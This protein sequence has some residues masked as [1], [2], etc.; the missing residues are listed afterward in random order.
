MYWFGENPAINAV[1]VFINV[2]TSASSGFDF[3]FGCFSR[4][5]TI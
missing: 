5:I 3:N 4:V 1:L 2:S